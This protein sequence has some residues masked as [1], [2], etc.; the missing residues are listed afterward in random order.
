MTIMQCHTYIVLIF[1]IVFL[2]AVECKFVYTPLIVSSG[3]IMTCFWNILCMFCGSC[4]KGPVL[5]QCMLVLCC[6]SENVPLCGD[7]TTDCVL[8]N[9]SLSDGFRHI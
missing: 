1:P 9:L 4:V 3:N 2:I 7:L 6:D 5:T 8:M